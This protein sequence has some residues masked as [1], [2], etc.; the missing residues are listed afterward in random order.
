MQETKGGLHKVAGDGKQSYGILQCK[1]P[2]PGDCSTVKP[3]PQSEITKMINGGV[4]G[5]S[6]GGTAQE[7]GIAAWMTKENGNV[8]AALRGYNTGGGTA[9]IP[10]LNDFSDVGAATYTTPSYVSS[11]GNR[12]MGVTDA[13]IPQQA[14]QLS[15][16]GFHDPA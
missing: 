12:L 15:Q 3:C 16:C 4:L 7:P 9:G 8:G 5:S 11:V 6:T 1:V 2:N 14:G 10:N 13:N